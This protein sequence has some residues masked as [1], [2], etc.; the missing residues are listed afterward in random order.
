MTIEQNLERIANALESIAAQIGNSEPM[1]CESVTLVAETGPKEEP[2]KTRGRNKKEPDAIPGAEPQS[3]DVD[4]EIPGL[5]LTDEPVT[6]KPVYTTQML[7]DVAKRMLAEAEKKGKTQEFIAFV[8][9]E[10]CAKFTPKAL[11]IKHIANAD[12][13]D[14]VEML[15]AGARKLGLTD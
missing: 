6:T 5:D 1:M 7:L 8:K 10:L 13:Y 15:E 3:E 14:A 2:K 11:A 4:D 12:A 9:N